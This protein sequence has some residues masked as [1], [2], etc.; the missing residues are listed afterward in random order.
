GDT[1]GQPDVFVYDRLTK[2]IQRVNVANDGTQANAAS[3]V[4]VISPD[5]SVV[6]FNSLAGLVPRDQ[7]GRWDTYVFDRTTQTLE[8]VSG[9]A[10]NNVPGFSNT[11]LNFRPALSADGRFVAFQTDAVNALDSNDLNSKFD[12]YVYDRLLKTWQ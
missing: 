10:Y 7:N 8:L 4:P 9:D 12:V 5:G 3:A 2:L 1:N 11:G 6:A